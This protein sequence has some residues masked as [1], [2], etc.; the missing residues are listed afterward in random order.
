VDRG[1]N[2]QAP[3]SISARPFVG[4]MDIRPLRFGSLEQDLRR[5]SDLVAD[6]S[7]DELARID[8]ALAYQSRPLS[9]NLLRLTE[10]L[11]VVTHV[12]TGIHVDVDAATE[13]GIVVLDNAGHN[14]ISV[15]EHAI[16]L[17]LSLANRIPQSDR[18]VRTR[19]RWAAGTMDLAGVELHGKTLGLLGFGNVGRHVARIASAGLG[20]RVLVF[21][22]DTDAVTAAGYENATLDEVLELS[23]VVSTHLPLTPS[24]RHIL[25]A[26]RFARM[27]PTA[28]LVHTAR[29][30]VVDYDA[31]HGALCDGTIAG[32]AFDT[33]PG[34]R[35]NPESPLIDLDNVVMTQHNAGLTVESAAR[36]GDAVIGGV[37]EVLGGTRPT[38]SRLVNP[39]V[40]DRRRRYERLEE[41]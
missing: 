38:V 23:D 7:D 19:V 13:L 39:A 14:A 12:G 17:M 22:L 2:V 34:H 21:E 20:M 10:R 31:L 35:A 37:W 40:W 1:L 8:V 15:A 27:K 32:A 18:V 36:M 3:T 11:V 29:G 41:S 33:W 28:L 26:K 16:G 9:Q 30:E 5:R 24:T 4:A 25:D 6:P